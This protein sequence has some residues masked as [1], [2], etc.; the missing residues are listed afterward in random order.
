[1]GYCVSGGLLFVLLCAASNAA[2]IRI[3]PLGDSITSSTSGH[4]SYR[5]WLWHDLIDAGHT[6]IIFVGTLTGVHGGAPLYK[7]FSQRHEGVWG[8]SAEYVRVRAAAWANATKPNVVLLDIGTT[9]IQLG[10]SNRST[11]VKISGIIRA[12]RTV[13]PRIKILLA[14]LSPVVWD[15]SSSIADLN[16][17]ILQL[18]NT[19]TRSASPVILVD[20]WSGF[21]PMVDTFDGVHPSDSGEQ[22]IAAAWFVALD[23]VLTGLKH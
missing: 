1:M 5:Y 4:A 12:L 19:L 14:Q 11:L 8:A 15:Y 10:H 23:D 2:P 3:M 18:A 17:S 21:D 7:D 20:L 13:N 16:S 22:K 9:D 6:S